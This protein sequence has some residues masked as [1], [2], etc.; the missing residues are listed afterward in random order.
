[1]GE[2]FTNDEMRRYLDREKAR[3]Y[4]MLGK[5]VDRELLAFPEYNKTF[6]L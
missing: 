2:E 4:I 3:E 6:K 5:K 1:M